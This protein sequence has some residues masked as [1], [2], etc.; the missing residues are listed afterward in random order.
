MATGY[1]KPMD[2]PNKASLEDLMTFPAEVV[3]R[4]MAETSET[5]AD[6]CTAAVTGAL[7][8]EPV[9]VGVRPSRKG[10]YT[11]VHIRIRVETAEELR[12]ASSVLRTIDGVRLVL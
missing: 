12:R 8:W 9:S 7:G 2:D 10:N 1:P 4:V 3:L 5:L 6:R 11:A